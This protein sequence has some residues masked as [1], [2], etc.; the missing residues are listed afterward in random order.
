MRKV[1]IVYAQLCHIC[2][3]RRVSKKKTKQVIVSNTNRTISGLA[4]KLLQSLSTA[5]KS[6]K[7]RNTDPT[8]TEVNPGAHK[9]EAVPIYL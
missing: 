9:W 7:L 6:K 4:Y 5:Q 1:I 3:I 8:K 2:Q